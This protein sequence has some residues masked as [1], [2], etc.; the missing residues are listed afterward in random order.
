[1]VAAAV[2]RIVVQATPQE[3][4]GNHAKA[5]TGSRCRIDARGSHRL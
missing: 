2:E 4:K 5:K 1:M 3:K